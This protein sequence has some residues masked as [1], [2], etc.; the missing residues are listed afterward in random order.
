MGDIYYAKATYLRRKGCPGG[1]FGD[2]ARS[3]GGPL[4]DLGV[5]VIDLTRYLMG[6]PKPVS[7]YGATFHKLGDRRSI[8]SERGYVSATQEDGRSHL[9]RGRSGQRHDS[10]R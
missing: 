3:G 9:Q 4:I 2:K 5:H 6:K 1:W 8:K 10:L 7:I